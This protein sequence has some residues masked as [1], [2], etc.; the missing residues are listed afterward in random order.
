MYLFMN[1]TF[2]LETKLMGF[3]IFILLFF[4]GCSMEVKETGPAQNKIQ[5]KAKEAKQYCIDNN[6][7]TTFCVLI[8]MKVHS[9]KYRFFTW[10]FG[11]NSI[12]DKS[13][14]SHGS[15]ANIEL[16]DGEQLPY[17]TNQPNSYCSSLGKYKIGKR[18][19]SSYGINVNYKLHGLEKTNSNAF[20]R[21]IVLHSFDGLSENEVFPNKAITSWGCPAV[22][23]GM[24]ERIDEKLQKTQLPVLLWIYH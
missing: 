19:V 2:P 6:F 15:C 16:P 9:G 14:C 11:L 18:G 13:L 24:M 1:I 12:V 21:I 10:D 17:F 5:L 4:T 20:D 23:N 7:D 22:S 3:F 8:D